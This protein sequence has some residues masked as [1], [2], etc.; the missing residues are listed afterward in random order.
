MREVMGKE[1]PLGSPL[2]IQY[3]GMKGVAAE[4]TWQQLV[5]GE[6]PMLG[7][8]PT[9]QDLRAGSPNKP[10]SKTVLPAWERYIASSRGF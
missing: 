3:L 6:A 4:H 2:T 7:S 1:N 9:A 10:E 8:W 5:E